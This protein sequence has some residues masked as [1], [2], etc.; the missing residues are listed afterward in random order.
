MTLKSNIKFTG[1][2]RTITNLRGSWSVNKLSLLVP[3]ERDREQYGEYSC[4]CYG[5]NGLRT[6]NSPCN[7]LIVSNFWDTQITLYMFQKSLFL[8]IFLFSFTFNYLLSLLILLHLLFLLFNFQQDPANETK[9]SWV[10]D[11]LGV[12]LIFM[13]LA[14]ELFKKLFLHHLIFPYSVTAESNIN[15]RSRKYRKWSF[16]KEAGD[17]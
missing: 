2:K 16:T 8:I 3:Q 1:I 5:A 10:W 15:R 13:I 14:S 12:F 9:R 7:W 4:S 6:F 11:T 17:C